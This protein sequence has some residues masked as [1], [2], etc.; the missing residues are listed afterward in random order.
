[1]FAVCEECVVL[2]LY[3]CWQVSEVLKKNLFYNYVVNRAYLLLHRKC[4]I[5]KQ[6]VA[7][8][9][10]FPYHLFRVITVGYYV[11]PGYTVPGTYNYCSHT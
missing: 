5:L 11:P 3:L 7:K 9:N 1:M 6:D 8:G 10:I 4:I 2:L